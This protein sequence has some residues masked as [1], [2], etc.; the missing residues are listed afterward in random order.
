MMKEVINLLMTQEYYNQS[1]LI[2]IAKGKY[3]IPTTLKKG[4]KQIKRISRWRKM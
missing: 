1:E 4:I 2:E 3:E